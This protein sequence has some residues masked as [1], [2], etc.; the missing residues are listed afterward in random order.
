MLEFF[1]RKLKNQENILETIN[2]IFA[3]HYNVY[4][5]LDILYVH[6]LIYDDLKCNHHDEFKKKVKHLY[7]K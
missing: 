6:V 7:F 1:G 4:L 5:E 2:S 3:I